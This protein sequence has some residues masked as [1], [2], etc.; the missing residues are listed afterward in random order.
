M[1]K[2]LGKGDTKPVQERI[3]MLVETMKIPS[4]TNNFFKGGRLTTNLDTELT[5]FTKINLKMEH[6]AEC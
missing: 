6:K 1:T 2:K 3:Q 4:L 5:P